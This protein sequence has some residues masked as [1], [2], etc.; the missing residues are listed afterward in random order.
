[1]LITSG[2]GSAA[3]LRRAEPATEM[4]LR[5]DRMVELKDDPEGVAQALQEK[6]HEFGNSDLDISYDRDSSR[7]VIL[8]LDPDTG[9]VRRELPPERLLDLNKRLAEMRG[10]LIDE[11]S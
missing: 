10:L 5:H 3:Q 1:M 11:K 8:L 4:E 9:E 6:L 2:G 7:F